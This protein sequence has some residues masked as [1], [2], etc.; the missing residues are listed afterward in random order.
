MLK[1][2]IYFILLHFIPV[3]IFSLLA[4]SYALPTLIFYHEGSTLAVMCHQHIFI[5]CSKVINEIKILS[6]IDPKNN[7]WMILSNLFS[8][9][10]YLFHT[11][12]I[13]D[14]SFPLFTYLIRKHQQTFFTELQAQNLFCLETFYQKKLYICHILAQKIITYLVSFQF[15]SWSVLTKVCSSLVPQ[16]SVFSIYLF[17][18]LRLFFYTR[19]SFP[20]QQFSDLPGKYFC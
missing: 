19:Y 4:P 9:I 7:Q 17:L 13:L 12:S 16:V 8:T 15:S 3:I 6:K 5:S 10:Y 18:M 20:A 1:L 2:M 14:C 11:A